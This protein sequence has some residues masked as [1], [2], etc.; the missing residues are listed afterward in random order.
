MD[1]NFPA[2]NKFSREVSAGRDFLGQ[3]SFVQYMADRCLPSFTNATQMVRYYSFWAWAFEM[4]RRNI[5]EDTKGENA[6]WYLMKL[7]TALM[8]SNKHRDPD[9]SGMPGISKI[10]H[11]SDEIIKFNSNTD[12]TKYSRD[13]KVTAYTAVQYSPSL[14]TL[15]IVKRNGHEYLILKYGKKLAKIFDKNIRSYKG[16]DILVSPKTKKIKWKLLKEMEDAFSLEVLPKEEQQVFIKIIEQSTSLIPGSGEKSQRV[17]TTMF[18]LDAVQKLTIKNPDDL[19]ANLWRRNYN[20]PEALVDNT[21]G[22]I[23]VEARRYY[24]IAIEAILS[25]FCKYISSFKNSTGDFDE[26]SNDVVKKLSR[27]K[28]NQSKETQFA[29]II[30]NDETLVHF[31]N[32]ITELCNKY[33]I[34]E[35]DLARRIKS[36][37]GK[38]KAFNYEMAHYAI[39]L[40]LLLYSRFSDLKKLKSKRVVHY[41]N[42]RPAY[43]VKHSFHLIDKMI[44]RWQDRPVSI[45]LNKIIQDFSLKLH[46]GVSQEK[47]MQT[48]NFTFRYT[49]AE[50]TGFELLKSMEPNR[51]SNKIITYIQLITNLG[52][53]TKKSGI[54]KLTSDGRNF[55]DI[56]K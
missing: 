27:F 16:Y 3:Q 25:S 44:S 45:A 42:Y 34:D 14:G 11:A 56:H 37:A 47:W 55:M 30:K 43:S 10:P 13:R 32:E 26:F 40:L 33:K 23:I 1:N 4:L 28:Y 7:E 12:V 17:Y 20:P 50:P 39:I 38:K 31:I 29:Q 36:L 8:I 21:E 6:W 22:W 24:Q 48:G 5:G 18:I 54:Y 15:N 52:L 41:W 53:I 46:L 51:T 9:M 35:I 2:P 19:L 49:R